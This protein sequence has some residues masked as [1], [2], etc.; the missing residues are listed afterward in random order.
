MK[1]TPKDLEVEDERAVQRDYLARLRQLDKNI[2]GH[3]GPRNNAWTGTNKPSRR[4]HRVG[5]LV[6][7]VALAHPDP[8]LGNMSEYYIGEC[9][10]LIHISEPTRPY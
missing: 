4:S 7:R 2:Q 9:L 6:G 3:E 8:E 1:L 10:S 5:E